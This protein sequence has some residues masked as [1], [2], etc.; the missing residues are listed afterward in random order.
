MGEFAT[1]G[2]EIGKEAIK[3]AQDVAQE[4]RDS[5]SGVIE[6]GDLDLDF[7]DAVPP[8]PA[9]LKEQ[10]PYRWEVESTVTWRSA[11][12]SHIRAT[13]GKY[14]KHADLART[15]LAMRGL[16]NKKEREQFK[17]DMEKQTL[18]LLKAKYTLKHSKAVAQIDTD[19][20][21]KPKPAEYKAAAIKAMHDEYHT[22]YKVKIPA[23]ADDAQFAEAMAKHIV[24]TDKLQHKFDKAWFEA[25]EARVLQ[26]A[27]TK[28]PTH[29]DE[30]IQEKILA[31]K[32]EQIQSAFHRSVVVCY[33]VSYQILKIDEAEVATRWVEVNKMLVAYEK[34]K[35][36]IIQGRAKAA[37][38]ILTTYNTLGAASVQPDVL[39]RNTDII[40]KSDQDNLN[41]DKEIV[42][43]LADIEKKKDEVKKIV[44][45]TRRMG[46]FWVYPVATHK[47]LNTGIKFRNTSA[48]MSA[49]V[50]RTMNDS[51]KIQFSFDETGKSGVPFSN[52][53]FDGKFRA[54]GNVTFELGKPP[55]GDGGKVGNKF[56]ELKQLV[57]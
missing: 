16:D 49:K 48:G 22:I 23:N 52:G 51:A 19:A 46:A 21:G 25:V 14:K 47:D 31:A 4:L 41:L 37:Q 28:N 11:Y 36:E 29:S 13:P 55:K 39:K 56:E 8:L 9:A 50:Q 43:K 53:M 38:E 30:K 3:I 42:D 54:M 44:E 5:I 27:K 34:E 2:V 20:Q 17:K 32:A 45:K 18:D 12:Y 10:G 7:Q 1:A 26:R 57:S 33:E 40:L 15:A 6:G 24:K 35:R